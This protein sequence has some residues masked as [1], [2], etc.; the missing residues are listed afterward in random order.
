MLFRNQA[1]SLVIH[2][3]AK[4][5]LFLE[6]LGKRADG[7]HEL[8]TVIVSIDRYDTLVLSPRRDE[9]V[10]LT[11]QCVGGACS[12]SDAVPTGSDNLVLRAAALLQKRTG[13]SAGAAIALRKRIPPA[14]GLGGGSSNAAA[15]LAGLN[16][17]WRCGL[18]SE[19]LQTLASELGSDVPFFLAGAPTALCRGRGERLEPLAASAR[20]TAVVVRP[21]AGLSTAAV[22]GRYRPAA[23]LRN[24]AAITQALRRGRLT[25]AARQMHNAL[26]P[27]AEELSD[28]VGRLRERFS[29]LPVL[30]HQL[31][32]SGSAYFALCAQ[33]RQA[34]TLAA[35]LR[36]ERVGRV[37]VA[38]CRL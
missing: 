27:A 31:S 9:A 5:N 15:A 34:A 16:R 30:G 18:S 37:F 14:S 19:A 23:P 10:T 4:L 13:C 24:A 33:R 32:G 6:V 8:E 29:R 35:R 20:V 25:E 17:M 38:T 11:V 22:Y 1:H 3:P 7:Y 21:R 2:T 28:E 12:D 36:S 26:Q